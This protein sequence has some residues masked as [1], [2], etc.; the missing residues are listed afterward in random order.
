MEKA[1]KIDV[2]EVAE[3]EVG[4]SVLEIF[5]NITVNKNDDIA[6]SCIQFISNY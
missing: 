4:Q 5:K 6:Y 3:V 1:G 2:G